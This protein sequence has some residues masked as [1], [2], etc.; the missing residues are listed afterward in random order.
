MSFTVARKPEA[1]RQLATIWTDAT[2]RNAVTRAADAIDK[3]LR[4]NPENLGESRSKGSTYL[5]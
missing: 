2:D 3:A 4:S 1:R 5:A